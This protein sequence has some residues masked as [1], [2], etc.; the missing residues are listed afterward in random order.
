MT[1]LVKQII[2]NDKANQ[3]LNDRQLARLLKG[4]DQRR[5]GQVN[6]AIKAGQLIRVKRGIYVLQNSLRKDPVH[7]FALAQQLIPGSYVTAE[8]A[9]SFHGWI[10]EAVRNVVSISTKKKSISYQHDI[11]GK[12]EFRCMTTQEGYFYHSVTRH[13]LQN[14]V[15]LIAEP[16]RALMDLIHLRKIAWQGLDYLIEG[17]RIDEQELKSV[18]LLSFTNLLNVYKGKRETRYIQE[19]AEALAL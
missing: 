9:L 11:L 7:P 18:P 16:V 3:V 10:P 1:T 17:L 5:Y 2:D 8:S 4:S 12:Y 6:R 14:Q 19:L 13:K 15:A